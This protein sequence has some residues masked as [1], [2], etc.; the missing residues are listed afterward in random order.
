M[1]LSIEKE[2]EIEIEEEE[3]EEEIIRYG[4]IINSDSEFEA[5]RHYYPKILNAELHPL[6]S[7]FL[8]LGINRIAARYCHLNPK[9]DKNALIKLLKHE[10]K[11]LKWSGAD[12][13]VTTT[14]RGNRQLTVIETNTCPSVCIYHACA[15]NK[16][17]HILFFLH[18]RVKNQCLDPMMN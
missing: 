10:P 11:H 6:V 16:I 14:E 4:T 3:E 15:K 18:F 1:N 7:N 12:L 17:I 8:S 5:V 9:I 13:F 2:K